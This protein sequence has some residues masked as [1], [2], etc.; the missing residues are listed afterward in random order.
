M[1]RLDVLFHPFVWTFGD[2]PGMLGNISPLFLGLLIPWLLF[3]NA[4]AVRRSRGCLALGALTILTW[5]ALEARALHTRYLLVAL[6]LAAVGLAPAFVTMEEALRGGR[7][8]LQTAARAGLVLLLAFWLAV[9]GWSAW[10]ALRYT[11]G[12]D[13]RADRYQRKDGFDATEWLNAN[14]APSERVSL[15]GFGP[16]RYLLRPEILQGSESTAEL[17]QAR[18]ASRTQPMPAVLADLAASGGFRYVVARREVIAEVVDAVPPHQAGPRRVT[19]DGS[20]YAVL[21]IEPRTATDGS[22]HP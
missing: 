1:P 17:E 18:E 16:Y 19:F 5:I 10:E 21:T 6:A 22:R 4:P 9:S 12:R 14:V 11:A 2:R 13:Q 15:L 7:R 3:R 8:G 20:P